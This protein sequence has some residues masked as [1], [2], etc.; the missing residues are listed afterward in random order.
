MGKSPNA[1]RATSVR[2]AACRAGT[3][4]SDARVVALRIAVGGR[5]PGFPGVP[6]SPAIKAD[7]ARAAASLVAQSQ[8]TR[9][10]S[11]SIRC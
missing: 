5:V 9:R 10:S 4:P 7:T 1:T 2:R 6:R 11:T 3:T 8:L